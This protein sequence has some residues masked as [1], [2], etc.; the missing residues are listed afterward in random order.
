MVFRIDSLVDFARIG[1]LRQAALIRRR[2]LNRESVLFVFVAHEGFSLAR[3]LVPPCHFY[4]YAR[5]AGV[6][7]RRT[8]FGLPPPSQQ[9]L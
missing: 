4:V 6:V 8:V 7:G 3:R 1:T 2:P 9:S 5:C